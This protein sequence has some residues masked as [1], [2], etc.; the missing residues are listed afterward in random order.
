MA[1]M[2]PAKNNVPS[3][4]LLSSS[5][6]SFL[7]YSMIVKLKENIETFLSKSPEAVKLDERL[8]DQVLRS[9]YSE[10][11]AV[12]KLAKWISATRDRL[13]ANNSSNP[14][15]TSK[16]E[17][18]LIPALHRALRSSPDLLIKLVRLDSAFD[19]LKS[20]AAHRSELLPTTDLIRESATFVTTG[21]I[22]PCNEE[23]SALGLTLTQLMKGRLHEL[24]LQ[25]LNTSLANHHQ[26]EISK[27]FQRFIDAEMVAAWKDDFIEQALVGHTKMSASVDHVVKELDFSIRSACLRECR[28]NAANALKEFRSQSRFDIQRQ[29]EHELNTMSHDETI[30]YIEN[31]ATFIYNRVYKELAEC[32]LVIEAE[33]HKEFQA[34]GNRARELVRWIQ[35]IQLEPSSCSSANDLFSTSADSQEVW[36][37]KERAAAHL[38]KH[39]LHGLPCNRYTIDDLMMKVEA[40]LSIDPAPPSIMK[41]IELLLDALQNVCYIQDIRMFKSTLVSGITK[42][43]NGLDALRHDIYQLDSGKVRQDILRRARGCIQL[44]P[45]CMRCCDENH[46]LI[47]APPGSPGNRHKCLLGHQYRALAR[48]S[49]PNTKIASLQL[50]QTMLDSDM[51]WF[52][53]Q[54]I[55]WREY[56]AKFPEWDFQSLEA[57]DLDDATSRMALIWSNVGRKISLKYP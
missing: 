42:L 45:F 11:P 3:N 48:M 44:C 34:E 27:I 36:R 7:D 33:A 5:G 53:N 6:W 4:K 29:I 19:V 50:C 41:H 57:D 47:V 28:K 15:N 39:L 55:Q 43:A 17:T 9:S 13:F 16:W 2:L 21:V 37:K 10:P 12:V 56:K 52:D 38:I 23:L 46:D 51:V 25:H 20:F 30:A 49:H 26:Q 40:R 24:M 1:T 32:S 18:M 31:T 54:F 8:I 35:S 22:R 14:A